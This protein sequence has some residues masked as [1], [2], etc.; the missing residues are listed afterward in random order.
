MKAF[1]HI[2]DPEAFQ[3]LADKTRRRIIHMLRA[4]EYTVSQIAEALDMTPQA[5]YHHIRKM[6]SADLIEVAREERID[7][8]IETYYRTTAEIFHLSHGKE[9]KRELTVEKTRDALR[10]LAKL[11]YKIPDDPDLA[12]KL[13]G[14]DKKMYEVCCGDK[15]PDN[16][17]EFEDLDFFTTQQAFEYY[18]LVSM[19]EE[20]FEAYLKL[21]RERW[22]LLKERSTSTTPR[23]KMR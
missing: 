13:V 10:S 17:E 16:V 1:K 14:I 19:K 22:K 15:W 3:L 4:K 8:F 9:G 20:E 11:G 18:T 7:H 6:K 21:Y 2:K 12:T 23:K 5:I